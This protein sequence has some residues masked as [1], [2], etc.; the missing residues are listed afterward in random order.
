MWCNLYIQ[1]I[2][3]TPL[4]VLVMSLSWKIAPISNTGCFLSWNAYEHHRRFRNSIDSLSQW[5][6]L[7]V[8]QLLSSGLEQQPHSYPQMLP[9]ELQIPGEDWIC[10][11]S[12]PLSLL[13]K[14]LYNCWALNLDAA[15]PYGS[16]QE[17]F[18]KITY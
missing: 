3:S 14:S 10:Q 9:K 7:L 16:N 13:A 17:T 2:C 12:Q 1:I 15:P 5:L 11:P 6:L 4:A 8:R 18:Y